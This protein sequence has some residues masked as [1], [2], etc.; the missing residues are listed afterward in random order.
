METARR[1]LILAAVV[2]T[3]MPAGLAA[4]SDTRGVELTHWCRGGDPPLHVSRHTTCDIAIALVN[5]LFNGPRLA[6]DSTRTMS[7]HPPAANRSYQ[8]LLLRRGD[9]VFAVGADGI[10]IRFYYDG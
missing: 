10:R 7:V 1:A 9:H 5:H 2:A 3:T 6:D 4:A 8:L